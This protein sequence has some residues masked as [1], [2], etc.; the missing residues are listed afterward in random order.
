MEGAGKTVHMPYAALLVGSL[1]SLLALEAPPGHA[2]GPAGIKLDGTLGPSAAALAGPTYNITQSL[3]KLSGGN[4]FFSFQYFNVATGETALFATTSAG[5]NNVISRVTGGYAS[6]IDGTIELQAASGA[7]NFFLINP[8]GVTFSSNAIIDVPAAFY[9]STA[10][11]LKFSDGNFYVDPSKMSTLSAAAPEAFGFLGTTRAPVN[12]EGANLSAGVNGAGDFQIAAGDVTVDGG[13]AL[14]GIQNSTGT[15]EVTAVGGASA[16]VPL[17]GPFAATD[18][19]VTIRNGGVLLTQGQGSTNGGAIEVNA[20]SLLIDG[21][22]LAIN[23]TAFQQTGITTLTDAAGTGTDA[24]GPITVA[25]GNDVSIANGGGIASGASGAGAAGN[26]SLSANTLMI[27]GGTYSGSTGVA[28]ETFASGSAGN[29]IV[30]LTGNA[31]LDSGGGIASASLGSGNAGNISLSAKNLAMDSGT[32]PPNF[33]GNTGIFDQTLSS[34]SAGSIV[35]NVA[36]NTSLLN[37]SEINANADGTTGNAGNITL[38]SGSLIINGGP[39]LLASGIYASA[40]F[41]DLPPYGVSSGTGGNI[42]INVTGSVLIAN[43]GDIASNTLGPGNSGNIS[44]SAGSLTID[45]SPPY[46]PLPADVPFYDIAFTGLL[47]YTLGSGNAG[48]ISLKLGS[49]S[50]SGGTP[51]YSVGIVSS[52]GN[53][54]LEETFG[55]PAG[56]GSAGSIVADVAGSVS[57]QD[58]GQISTATYGAG[59]AGAV[60]IT[61]GSIKAGGGANPS[62]ISSQAYAGSGGQTGQINI[63]TGLLTLTANGSID[64]SNGAT[65]ANPNLVTPA[66]IKVTAQEIDMLGGAITAASTGNVAAS[67][68]DIS[69]TDSMHMD[70][71]T[72]STSAVD[73]NGGPITISGQGPLFISHSNVTTSVTG[74]TNGNGGDITITVP[75]IVLDTGVIQANTS[76]P[77]ASGG[78]VSIDALGLVPSFQSFVLG[79]GAVAFVANATGLNV[80]QAAAP[81]G[82]S[83]ALSVTVPTLDLGNALLG[84]T[85]HPSAPSAL[86]RSLCGYSKGSSLAVAGR[87][88]IAPTAYDP[89]WIEQAHGW[90][91]STSATADRAGAASNRKNVEL[92][93]FVACR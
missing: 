40:Y 43:G 71:S 17:S 86:G 53:P 46:T 60:T 35:I 68:I 89:L 78:T 24:A 92:G 27:N 65:V 11:Y 15:I 42:A 69:Y 25:V 34:G 3:G 2:S 91:A 79:G 4:L 76:A 84:L 26:I 8:N 52:D 70:P 47:A 61:A 59:P 90:R 83:G 32:T 30:K 29:V 37:F 74:T 72:I 9:V 31:S 56:S 23:N 38:N 49:L 44:M 58:G 55:L 50:I 80:V 36:D 82:V 13:G 87:G 45:R 93:E 88:G 62:G 63:S 57:L 41:Y 18:G 77:L 85:G 28:S 64:T 75:E 14:I 81:D 7:P 6:T 10:N 33:G 54:G 1:V 22:G 5:I 51:G 48:Q 66:Q 73:G 19:T 67:G 21:L 39:Y 20:G 12:I 16:E